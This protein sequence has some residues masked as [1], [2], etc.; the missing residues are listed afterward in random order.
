[1]ETNE[2]TFYQIITDYV[3]KAPASEL[4]RIQSLIKA[5]LGDTSTFEGKARYIKSTQGKLHC[6]KFIKDEK[7]W[8]LKDAKD[9]M[10]SL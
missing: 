10:D 9:F 5:H 1:M 2:T 7:N 4:F 8:T 6:V 3:W